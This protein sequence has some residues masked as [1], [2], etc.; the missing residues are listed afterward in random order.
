MAYFLQLV[1]A[2]IALGCIYALIGLGFSI[3]FKASEVINFAQGELLLVGAYIVSGG[4]FV[5]HLPFLL[6]LVLGI[7][8]TVLIGLL[9]ER[10]LLRRMLGRPPFTLLM[11][12]I[13]LDII[14]LTSVIVIWGSQPLPAAS[15]F[16]VS[17]G[18]NLGGVHFATNDLWTIG[19]TVVLCALLFAFFRFT[20]YGLAMRATALDQEAALAVGINIRRVYALAWGMA[21]GIATLGGVF[22]AIGS[23]TITP[24]LGSIALLAFPAII[25]GGLDSVSGAVV[26]GLVIGL[27]LDLTAG[28][29]S[30]LATVLGAGFHD[31]M[32]Y[33]L[34]ILVLLI[35][36]YGLFGSRKVERI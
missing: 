29:E 22:L 10:F 14:L 18:F 24:T 9:F 36:P 6:A 30:N 17:S 19:I 15:P 21:A 1:F 23:F 28:Y 3:I 11:M 35:R 27:A 32:P 20:K 5:W 12:T 26:G 33:L 31:I 7:A 16:G 34:M 2:G 4:V 25:L 8:I 13:G